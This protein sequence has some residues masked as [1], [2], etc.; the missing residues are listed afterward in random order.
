MDIVVAEDIAKAY[1]TGSARM[2]ALRGVSL[3]LKAGETVAVIGPSGCGKTTLLDVIG[4]VLRATGGSLEVGGVPTGSLTDR[5]AARLRNATF[6]YVRQDFALM[7]DERTSTNV[8]LPLLYRRPRKRRSERR[9]SVQDSLAEYGVGEVVD[10]RVN[11]LSGGEKQR[12][13]MARAMVNRAQVILADEPTGCLDSANAEA[14][15]QALLDAA[16]KGSA[17]LM[18]THNTEMAARCDRVIELR[19]G[20]QV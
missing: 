11:T 10:R 6:G 13:A 1:G 2:E 20:L 3:S 8:E 15:F 4:L 9:R 16:A 18:A 14:V 17:V 5:A 19:D 7:E 12:V